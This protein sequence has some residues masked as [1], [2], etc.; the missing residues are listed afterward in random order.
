[1][2]NTNENKTEHMESGKVT[3]TIADEINVVILKAME[4]NKINRYT[5]KFMLTL[6]E[7]VKRW[8][9]KRSLS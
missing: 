9:G 6:Q 1:M 2:H 8:A 5:E 3:Q 7:D 4:Y